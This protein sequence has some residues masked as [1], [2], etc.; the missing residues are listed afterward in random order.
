MSKEEEQRIEKEHAK[1][2][3]TED[4]ESETQLTKIFNDL[5]QIPAT[6]SYSFKSPETIFTF[7]PPTDE[8]IA[9]KLFH[10]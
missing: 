2:T 6:E 1:I 7:S 3:D 10:V 5:D 4:F 9:S 8:V